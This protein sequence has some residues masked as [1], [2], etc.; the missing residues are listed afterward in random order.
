[1]TQRLTD[2]QITRVSLVDKGANARVM[3][4]LKRNEEG[5]V[6]D[7]AEAAQRASAAGWLQKAADWLLGK[8][9]VEPVAKADTFANVIAG[10]QLEDALDGAFWTLRDVLWSAFYAWDREADAPMSIEGRRALI[11]QDLDEFKA[12]LLAR[13]DQAVAKRDTSDGARDR[14]AVAAVVSK[15]G[16]KISGSRLERLT[17]AAEALT[18]VLDEVNEAVADEAAG[19][20]E[21]DTVEKADIIAAMTEALEPVNKRLEA[22]E[23]SKSPAPVVKADET[24]DNELTLE[25]VAAAVEKIADSVAELVAGQGVRKSLAGQDAGGEVK[26]RGV[27][28][29][30]LD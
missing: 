22:L 17:A 24:E 12:Y 14:A 11:V 16:R 10:Q 6:T 3:A 8:P 30:I 7:Q 2:M 29:G 20:A 26:K 18:S 1:M 23:A 15:V 27:F 28:S 19:P 25:G 9:E 5:S 13:M 4:I 21:E